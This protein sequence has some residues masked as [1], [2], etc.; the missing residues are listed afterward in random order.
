MFS[1]KIQSLCNSQSRQGLHELNS[2]GLTSPIE[3]SGRLALVLVMSGKSLPSRGR[4]ADVHLQDK[5][6]GSNSA[7]APWDNYT[8]VS[9]RISL[10]F[11]VHASPLNLLSQFEDAFLL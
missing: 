7:F 2:E 8:D 3:S 1:W 6:H 4:Q 9:A 5:G 11:R 10:K